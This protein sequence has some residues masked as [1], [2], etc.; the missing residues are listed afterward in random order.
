MRVLII[1]S[2]LSLVVLISG[3]SF[4]VPQASM[5]NEEYIANS[6]QFEVIGEVTGKSKIANILGFGFWKNR[7][8]KKAYRDALKKAE[9]MGAEGLIC[10]YSDVR[11]F[12]FFGIYNSNVT[13]VYAKAY[14]RK[15]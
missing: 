15:G 11:F 6:D 14:K 1:L 3:C 8:Y 5:V 10:I 2:V 9:D 4:T 13:Y 12:S 7:G